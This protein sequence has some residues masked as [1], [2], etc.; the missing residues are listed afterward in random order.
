MRTRQAHERDG[1]PSRFRFYHSMKSASVAGLYHFVCRKA[2]NLL[3]RPPLCGTIAPMSRGAVLTFSLTLALGLGAG[4]YIGWVISPVEYTNTEPRSLSQ[5]YKDD[6]ILMIATAY[7]QDQD[8][9]TARAHLAQLGFA[10]PG[11]AVADAARRYLAAQ[12]QPNDLRRLAG[13]A[14]ALGSLPPE[15]QDFAP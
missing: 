13:L 10:E 11:L 1:T 4:L 2:D 7:A 5:R 9:E 8:L 3:R 15:L 14:A 12:A 6:Y